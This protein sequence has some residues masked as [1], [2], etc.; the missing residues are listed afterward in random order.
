[1]ILFAFSHLRCQAFPHFMYNW[2]GGPPVKCELQL[3]V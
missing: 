2:S 1:M 3:E